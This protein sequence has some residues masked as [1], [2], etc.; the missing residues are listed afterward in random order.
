[1]FRR[2]LFS[3]FKLYGHYALSSDPIL[4]YTVLCVS[5]NTVNLITCLIINLIFSYFSKISCLML[6]TYTLIFLLSNDLF[7]RSQEKVIT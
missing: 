7:V 5:A 4:E 3:A 6:I 1:M 2:N